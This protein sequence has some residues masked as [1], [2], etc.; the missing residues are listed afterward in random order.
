MRCTTLPIHS[1]PYVL[2][3]PKRPGW[4][5]QRFGSTFQIAQLIHRSAPIVA[6][7]KDFVHQGVT[8]GKHVRLKILDRRSHPP[9]TQYLLPPSVHDG[10]RISCRILR[11]FICRHVE[12]AKMET[13]FYNNKWTIYFPLKYQFLHFSAAKFNVSFTTD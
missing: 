4:N 7:W 12:T 13:Q 10:Y 2:T 1:N 5:L 11:F 8:D 9:L 6:C 3:H